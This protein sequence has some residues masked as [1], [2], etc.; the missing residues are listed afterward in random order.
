[1]TGVIAAKMSIAAIAHADRHP[2]IDDDFDHLSNDLADAVERVRHLQ[3]RFRLDERGDDRLAAAAREVVEQHANGGVQAGAVR[4]EEH[5]SEL[6]SR[7]YLVCR[8]L[9]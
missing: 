7:Q 9:L 5:T 1:M 6:Q 4:S 8:L 2:G 3:E